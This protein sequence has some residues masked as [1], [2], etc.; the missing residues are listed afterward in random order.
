MSINYQ[1]IG[2][3]VREHRC[4]QR[5]KQEALA[6]DAEISISYLS[7]IENGNKQASLLAFSRIAD[8]LNVSLEMLLF[9]EISD[10]EEDAFQELYAIIYDCGEIEQN[11]IMDAVLSTATAV[12]RGLRSSG[13]L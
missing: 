12:K 8:A 11:I 4:R 9:G 6:W 5:L 13:L 7:G 1:L 3:R 2:N 10:C